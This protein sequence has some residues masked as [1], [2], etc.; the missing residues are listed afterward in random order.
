M[1]RIGQIEFDRIDW[2]WDFGNAAKVKF[3]RQNVSFSLDEFPANLKPYVIISDVIQVLFVP[4]S[5]SFKKDLIRSD[6]II[7]YVQY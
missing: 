3:K 1:P 2:L 7:P 5:S 6:S 4:L